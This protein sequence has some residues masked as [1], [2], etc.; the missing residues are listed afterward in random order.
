MK[1]LQSFIYW[2]NKQVELQEHY[3]HGTVLGYNLTKGENILGGMLNPRQTR[4]PEPHALSV[5]PAAG[6]KMV[7]CIN[8]Q[9]RTFQVDRFA[10]GPHGLQ[11]ICSM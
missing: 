6:K 8:A 2:S 5:P 4:V 9:H 11:F 10:P 7:M 3:M 1:R